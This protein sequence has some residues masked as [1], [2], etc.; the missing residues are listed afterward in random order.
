MEQK[1]LNNLSI[2]ELRDLARK[3]GVFNPTVLKKKDLINAICDVQDGKVKPYI[4]KTKQGRPPKEIGGYDKLVGIFL[5]KDIL[6]IK[7]QEESIFEKKAREEEY[8][9]FSDNPSV[10]EGT[11]GDHVSSGY[12]EI[13]ANLA[14]V[15][16]R[17]NQ[18]DEQ[19]LDTTFV[20]AKIIEQYNLKGGD[21][22]LCLSS[23]IADDRPLVLTHITNINGVAIEDYSTD[24]LE[25]DK[26]KFNFNASNFKFNSDYLSPLSKKVKMC[27]GDTIFC[28]PE[29]SEDFQVFVSQLNNE[30]CFD[31]YIYI[32]P[33][34]TTK[35]YDILKN[36]K[37]DLF[38]SDFCDSLV[39]QNRSTMLG[40]NRAK[41]LAEQGKNVCL[42]INDLNSLVGLD[43]YYTSELL[44]SK[45]ILSQAK[46][47][48]KGS[49]TIFCNFSKLFFDRLN[50]IVWTVFPII[51]T[52]R[53]K[54]TDKKVI[55]EESFRK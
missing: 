1:D 17:K 30:T 44:V 8:L 28:Y 34:T 16:R 36:I 14:G 45:T 52:V 21:Y 29:T 5:P 39:V 15:L 40:L 42:I 4:A 27:Y 47:L 9:S 50:D 49:V 12:L 53:I 55:L 54:L 51:E 22:I 20:P 26:L 6:D 41:R 7:T 11:R 10:P 37:G 31:S 35:D 43:R 24:R 38:C 13:L 46:N 32:S 18:K 3:V 48:D 25:Y 23:K 2:F 19:I 33:A